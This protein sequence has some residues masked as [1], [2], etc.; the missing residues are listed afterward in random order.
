M[1]NQKRNSQK[2]KQIKKEMDRLWNLAKKQAQEGEID[3][4]DANYSKYYKLR[5]EYIK[6]NKE[7]L[8]ETPK[9]S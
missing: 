3:W 8:I 6:L 2:I 5:G 1:V 4:A 9:V 7:G